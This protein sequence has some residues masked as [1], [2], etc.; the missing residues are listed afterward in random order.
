MPV[1]PVSVN[2]LALWPASSRTGPATAQ[3]FVSTDNNTYD[4]A[5]GIVKMDQQFN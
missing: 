1:N 4:S 3:N 2:L 5:N